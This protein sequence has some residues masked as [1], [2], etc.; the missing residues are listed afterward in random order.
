MAEVIDL[1]RKLVKF[2]SFDGN[3]KEIIDFLQEYS[4]QCG[5]KARELTFEHN[6]KTVVNLCASYGE[7][8]PHLLFAG[9][10]DVVPAGDEKLWQQPPF[11]AVI[12]DDI[13]YGRGIADMKGGAACFIVACKD[14][15]K[16][17]KFA[18]K[19]TII[20]SGDE[21]E[22]VVEGTRRIMEQLHH[23]GEKFDFVLVGEP[24]NPQTMGDEI[25]VGRRGD[26]VLHITSHGQSGHTAY[27]PA[28][29]NAA[30]NLIN[31]LYAMQNDSLDAGNKFFGPSTMHVTTFDVGNGATNVVPNTA[32]ATIDIRFNSEHT[33]KDIEAWCNRHISRTE[34]KFDVT[35]EYIGESFLSPIDDNIK[36][37]QKII[38]EHTGKKPAYSTA[39]GTSDARF[40][41]NYCP[42]VE[43]GLTNGTIHKVNECESVKNI[44]TLYD[45]DKEFLRFFFGIEK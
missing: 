37:L 34:G 42:V 35:P 16:D 32:K 14:F 27:A 43:Y 36:A 25:K 39:G 6:G 33:Y 17:N 13:F 2:R 20:L 11:D 41:K 19:I 23:E 26:I 44:E 9:H 28:E 29:S 21:E 45:I 3:T 31:L 8:R 22:P 38:A 10:I 15:I 1:C 4:E 7:G 30:R 40:V 12:K 5:F 24:S 18:G